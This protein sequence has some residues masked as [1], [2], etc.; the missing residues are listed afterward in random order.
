MNYFHQRSMPVQN[1]QAW[2][3]LTSRFCRERSQ[4]IRKL[5]Q[6]MY[7]N[8]DPQFSEQFYFDDFSRDVVIKTLQTALT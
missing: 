5:R 7:Q 6:Y 8:S 2:K 4:T 3:L 1:R